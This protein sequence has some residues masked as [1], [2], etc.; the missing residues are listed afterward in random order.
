MSQDQGFTPRDEL[1][2]QLVEKLEQY[3]E[4]GKLAG[5]SWYGLDPSTFAAHYED[6]E[7][8]YLGM[9]TFKVKLK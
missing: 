5:I 9:R 1:P 7:G 6:A 3:F 2:S 4:D 8:R